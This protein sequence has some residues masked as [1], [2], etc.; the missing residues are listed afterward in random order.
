METFWFSH[1]RFRGA[2]D[3]AFDSDFRF[4]PGYKLSDDSNYDSNSDSI[5]SENQPLGPPRS[6][7]ERLTGLVEKMIYKQK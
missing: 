6:S 1:L 3:S 7:S 2:Y 4:L 5:A